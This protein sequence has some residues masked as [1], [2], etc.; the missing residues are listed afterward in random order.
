MDINLE[1]DPSVNS[2]P[3][4]FKIA[5]TAAANYLDSLIT[6]PITVNIAVGWGEIEGR[7][8]TNYD[9]YGGP[10]FGEFVSYDQLTGYLRSHINSAADATALAMLPN[11]S[12]V[13]NSDF[14]I[15]PAE[16]EAWGLLPATDGQIAGYVG[17]SSTY[18]A[19]NFSPTDGAVPGKYDFVAIAEHELTHALGRV[20]G[21]VIPPGTANYYTLLDLFRYAAPGV[22]E[23]V[24]G[25]PNYF[26]ING[27]LTNLDNFSTVGDLSDWVK[28]ATPDAF[29]YSGTLGVE[30]PVTATDI[31]EMNVLGF[32][33][34]CF[35]AGTRIRTDR[36]NVAVEH[37]RV[38]DRAITAARRRA[39]IVWIGRRTLDCSRHKRP[40]DVHPVRVCAGAF[41]PK[42]PAR[43]LWLSP[44]HSVFVEGVLIP[45]RYLCNNATIRQ[46]A[47][48]R[49]TYYHVELARH[50]ILL[51]EGLPAES[52]LD[53]GNRAS[54]ENA[55]QV[56]ILHPDFARRI[57]EREGCAPLVL[58]GEKLAAASRAL[59][60]R[61]CALGHARTA[62]ADL[63]LVVAGEVV[64]PEICGRM[65]RFRLRGTAGRARLV[66]RRSVTAGSG[67]C[68]RLG[69]AV[70]R[71]LRDGRALALA[72]PR[73]ASGWHEVETNAEAQAWRWTDGDG[74]LEL[75]EARTLDIE[76]IPSA[77]YWRK[78]PRARV[79]IRPGVSPL[80]PTKSKA[81]G[82]LP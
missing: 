52:Y 26:S 29:S 80:D 79:I 17:F 16:E 23:L 81:L 6:N 30:R 47:A 43:D 56:V 82:T 9:S 66:S 3:A 21:L 19:Y 39:P 77:A 7:P 75:G 73:L 65:H 48:R 78:P 63:R 20:S 4:G 49:I 44:D 33:T 71:L 18:P 41:G 74:G 31:T 8:I 53:T 64:Q 24:G 62:D 68:R 12:P 22:R 25:Q 38:G 5:L 14:Y 54:F 60:E 58:E 51:A 67:D 34:A 46:E 76:I 1:Y 10:G 42:R 37:L 28:S 50:D 70:A 27:G 40:H 32:A 11:I 15:S 57:W 45:I 69:V 59:L 72:D 55:D 2:A 36:G 61:A 13:G 35:A